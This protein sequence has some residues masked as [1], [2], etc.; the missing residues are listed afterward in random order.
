MVMDNSGKID[1][2]PHI[3][4]AVETLELLLMHRDSGQRIPVSAT[5]EFKVDAGVIRGDF[6]WME[7]LTA[8]DGVQINRFR[9]CALETCN[10]YFYAAREDSRGCS[11]RHT[12]TLRQRAYRKP[13]GATNENP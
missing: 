1:S 4:L 11:P 8:L 12:S 13:K 2:Q 10:H 5:V 9:R 7:W 3:R 6:A